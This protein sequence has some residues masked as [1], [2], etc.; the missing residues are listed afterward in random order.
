MKLIDY[1]LESISRGCV[2]RFPAVWPYE[3]YVDLLV[4]SMPDEDSEHGLVVSTG[5][6]AGLILVR[7]P[8]E[9]ESTNSRSIKYQWVI[10]N[11]A[12]WIYP[13]CDVK[14]VLIIEHYDEPIYFAK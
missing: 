1:K 14:D 11:W 12:K 5:H 2:F 8:K 9:C 7:L 3:K 4:V 6:K 13:E 10:D